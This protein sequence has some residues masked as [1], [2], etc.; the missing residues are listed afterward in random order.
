M[1]IWN[2]HMKRRVPPVLVN[3]HNTHYIYKDIQCQEP[4]FQCTVT[5]WNALAPE[6]SCFADLQK[7]AES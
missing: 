1:K 4:T 2:E 3:I 5:V 6:Y 7:V